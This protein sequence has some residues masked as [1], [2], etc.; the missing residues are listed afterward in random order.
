MSL[1]PHSGPWVPICLASWGGYSS[2]GLN[3]CVSRGKLDGP[4]E[5]TSLVK[6]KSSSSHPDKL[7]CQRREISAALRI[8]LAWWW[9]IVTLGFGRA[10]T[11]QNLPQLGSV[12]N[13]LTEA[14]SGGNNEIAMCP[15]DA[16]LGFTHLRAKRNGSEDRRR[17]NTNT[18]RHPRKMRSAE[19]HREVFAGFHEVSICSIRCGAS[20]SEHAVRPVPSVTRSRI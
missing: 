3:E 14:G 1:I 13:F 5:M 10:G 11:R 19:A 16:T 9:P 8:L 7:S 18:H 20:L 2:G 6:S 12:Y 17:E 4:E 15:E